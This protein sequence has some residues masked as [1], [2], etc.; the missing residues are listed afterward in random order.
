MTIS[1]P[2]HRALSTKL[3]GRSFNV[4]SRLGYNPWLARVNNGS[5][6]NDS[7]SIPTWAPSNR[8]Y[9][10]RTRTYATEAV[11]KPASRPKAYTGRTPAKKTTKAATAK[12]PGPKTAEG[13]AKVGAK[14]KAKTEKATPGPK[15]KSTPKSKPGP[16]AKPGPKPK[17]KNAVKKI[18]KKAPSKATVTKE[19]I[20]KEKEL[21]EAAL[22]NSPK[23]LP[24]GPWAIFFQEQTQGS[25]TVAETAQLTKATGEKYRN[26]TP[27]EK[28]ACFSTSMNMADTNTIAALQP[29]HPH[30]Q[31]EE[32]RGS[33]AVAQSIQPQPDRGRQ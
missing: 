23:K 2:V 26:L 18:V 14:P 19:R 5:D 22:L 28:E 6:S 32:R 24:A 30:K 10:I 12:K 33:Q 27:E 29:P 25:R 31:R 7:K 20:A 17:P 8:V 13:K 16:K 3:A 9:G 15:A 11:K 4:V 1:I 21:N